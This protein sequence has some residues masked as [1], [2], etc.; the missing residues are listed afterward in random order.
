MHRREVLLLKFTIPIEGQGNQ[1]LFCDPY[2]LMLPS[3]KLFQEKVQGPCV[4][5]DL[6]A[7]FRPFLVRQKLNRRGFWRNSRRDGLNSCLRKPDD[8]AMP[9]IVSRRPMKQLFCVHLRH[10]RFEQVELL[11]GDTLIRRQNDQCPP[12]D[13]QDQNPRENKYLFVL[14]TDG[15]QKYC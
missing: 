13:C 4:S 12:K 1:A 7:I 11:S 5:L 15:P 8:R 10:A 2:F 9:E 3:G 6:T 14:H